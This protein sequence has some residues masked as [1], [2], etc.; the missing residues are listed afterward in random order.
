MIN[1]LSS[2][3]NLLTSL[4][5]GFG[6]QLSQTDTMQ[7][8]VRRYLIS[9]NQQLLNNLYAEHGIIQ[10]L[11]DLPIDDAFR[12]GFVIKSS[13]LDGNDM[14]KSR[15]IWKNTGL[16]LQQCKPVNGNAYFGAE[17][18]SLQPIKINHA[19][20]CCRHWA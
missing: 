7:F 16:S 3:V 13:Q 4:G 12:N 5:G 14:K 20:K 8:N 10:T 6:N 18:S 2:V 19:A 17:Q 11:I 1:S 9:N 15:L